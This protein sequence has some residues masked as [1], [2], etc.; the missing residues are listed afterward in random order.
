MEAYPISKDISKGGMERQAFQLI[1]DESDGV[2]LKDSVEYVQQY[3]SKVSS[4]T[5][6][7]QIICGVLAII[8][9][10]IYLVTYP[11]KIPPAKVAVGIWAGAIFV[12]SGIFGL[13]S[14]TKRR[15]MIV[16]YFVLSILSAVLA[17]VGIG[18]AIRA[19]VV[20]QYL[21]PAPV[22]PAPKLSIIVMIIEGLT[23]IVAACCGCFARICCEKLQVSHEEYLSPP[24][25]LGYNSSIPVPSGQIS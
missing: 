10:T 18:F 19:F 25:P 15:G 7:I 20:D 14:S 9:E 21:N 23:G 24:R 13:L 5:G 1:Q 11:D 16:A 6:K 3:N 2:S 17:G 8:L 4:I 12:I 22:Q